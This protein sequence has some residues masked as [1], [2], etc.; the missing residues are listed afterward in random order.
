MA[1]PSSGPLPRATTPYLETSVHRHFLDGDDVAAGLLIGLHHLLEDARD[2]LEQHVG[3]QQREGLVADQL[4]GAPDG[5]AEAQRL[6]LAGEAGLAGLRQ[7]ALQLVQRPDLA[8]HFE[9][10]FELELLVEMVL[11]HRF[12]AP[13]DEDEML[14][15]GLARLVDRVLDQRPVDDRQHFLGHRLG[16]GQETGAKAGHGEHGGADAL[17]QDRLRI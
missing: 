13:G 8:A 17:R 10:V 7:V 5:V 6:L 16:G 4:A 2:A 3:Q 14:D 15:P 11:D 12:V 9:R 1:K